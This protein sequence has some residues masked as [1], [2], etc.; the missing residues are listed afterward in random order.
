M[1]LSAIPFTA[2]AEYSRI[3]DIDDEDFFYIV[4]M[5]DDEFMRLYYLR[6]KKK[7]KNAAI[8]SDKNNK[9]KR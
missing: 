9:N 5:M 7:G 2:I 4:R 8:N 1:D 6:S 3:Y